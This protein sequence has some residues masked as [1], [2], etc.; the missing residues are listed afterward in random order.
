MNELQSKLDEEVLNRLEML[1][2]KCI[3][4]G[5]DDLEVNVLEIDDLYF[6]TILKKVRTQYGVR[7]NL[8][9]KENRLRKVRKEYRNSHFNCS[10][11][12]IAKYKERIVNDDCPF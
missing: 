9:E 4:L 11:S 8:W 6:N 2:D 7:F 5:K 12:N 1:Y 10:K 3:W